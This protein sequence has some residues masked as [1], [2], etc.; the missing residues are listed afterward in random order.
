MKVWLNR[1][2]LE[3]LDYIILTHISVRKGKSTWIYF[4]LKLSRQTSKIHKTYLICYFYVVS[5]Y[6]VGA[7]VTDRYTRNIYWRNTVDLLKKTSFSEILILFF[8]VFVIAVLLRIWIKKLLI[9]KMHLWMHFNN[10]L[11]I[12]RS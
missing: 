5:I 10:P 8:S 12:T 6:T 4:N 2:E 3:C 11:R 7:Y 9:I 1:T